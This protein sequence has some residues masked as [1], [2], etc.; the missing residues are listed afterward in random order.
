MKKADLEYLFNPRHVAIIGASHHERKIGYTVLKNVIESGY[1]G[2]IYPINPKGGVILGKKVYKDIF[3]IDGEIDLAMVVVPASIA[4]NVIE[5]CARKGVKFSIVI[6]SGFSEIG[7]IDAEREM[8]E[9]AKKYGMRILG[10]NVFGIYSASAP[11][12]ATFGPSKIYPGNIAVIS[13][14][15]AL[16]IAMIGKTAEENIG[17]S[18][19]VSIGNKADITEAD[20]MSHVF[21]DDITKV[22]FLYIE[23]LENGR[24]L[25]DMVKKKPDD[26]KIVAIKAG[27]SKMGV[28][29]VASHTGS[30]AGSDKIF[31]AAFKQAGILRAE[32][33]EE[34]FNWV[35]TLAACPRPSGKNVVIITNGG[36]LG[37]LAA[38]ACEKYG[39]DLMNDIKL[40]E[41]TFGGVIPRFGSCRNPVDL[42]GQ[43]GGN[44][45]KEALER[46]LNEESIHAIIALYCQTD[47]T[48][49]EP[50]MDTFLEMQKKYGRKKPI[51]YSLF[52]GE[53]TDKI[54]EQL[55]R[56]GI[57][58]FDDVEDAVS[59]L[60]A[61][62][63][64]YSKSEE[65]EAE[66]IDI[67]EKK[68]RSVIQIA[69]DEER[70]QLLGTEAKEIM[71]A[72]GM[73]VPPFKVARTIDEAVKA[74][75]EVGY[76]VVMKVVSEDIVHKTDMGGVLL[77]ID[78][79]KEVVE[80]Y[81]AIIRNCKRCAP[82]ANIRGMEIAKMVQKGVE[83]I[84]GSTTDPSFGK[85]LM[86]G[87][88][89]IY[90]EVLKDVAFRVAP[91]T[92]R[93][94]EKMIRE[95]SSYP[96]LIGVRGES[97]KDINSVIDAIYRVGILVDR[98][99]EISELDI[100][101]LV[102]YEKGAKVLDARMNIEVKK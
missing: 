5:E 34:G 10:P 97:R 32:S 83:I 92:K 93:E 89:G 60:N 73:D 30:L 42:T 6:T 72:A 11:I 48:A 64:A 76:P 90:V 17:L 28:R 86:F 49:L 47:M 18:T 8:M 12:N 46:A 96:L 69:L 94:I 14:S 100:N 61:L 59:A 29:A 75:E 87:L 22:I 74:A 50:L 56:N 1:K 2:K 19:I 102:V 35:S 40:L 3:S 55:K 66:T 58:A 81:E 4:V 99:P 41:R 43:A 7:N 38:D 36:G 85:V 82:K 39:V 78:D 79:E 54:L 101:P 44:D 63:K 15:G 65:E 98:F 16:G 25:M 80:G 62:Y 68:I 51:I 84:I 37:V 95:I 67:D 53:G 45:Y 21:N 26:I 27:K 23:G 91:V 31:D 77:D 13:Q 33:L 20:I 52:G 71:L 24:E 70:T 9:K 88:G 57:P